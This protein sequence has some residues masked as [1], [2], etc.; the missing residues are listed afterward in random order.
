M[1]NIKAIKN[2][3]NSVKSTQKIT[4]AMKLVASIKF[5]K[6]ER[7]VDESK[8]AIEEMD[9]QLNDMFENFDVSAI[10]PKEVMRASS[11]KVSKVLMIVYSSSKGMCGG[12]NVNIAKNIRS[13][14]QEL[15]SKNISVDIITIGGK[16]KGPLLRFLDPSQIEVIQNINESD[17]I[18]FFKEL[19]SKIF[20]KFEDNL[21]QEILLVYNK[22]ISPVKSEIIFKNVLPL[23]ETREIKSCKRITQFEQEMNKDLLS[24]VKYNLTMRLY[25][26]FLESLASEHSTRMVA[27]DSANRNAE[28]MIKKLTLQYNQT[29]QSAIT[30]ELVEIISGAEAI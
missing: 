9:S 25:H 24:L 22:F 10:L 15:S 20:T 5:K 13:K 23:Y 11:D 14:I 4:L 19:S 27:M 7:A 21:Y 6:A 18:P 26:G 12:F 17:A 3:L 29:R 1:S 28:E 30:N 8:K 2:R 16:I